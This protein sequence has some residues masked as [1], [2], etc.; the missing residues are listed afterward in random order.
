MSTSTVYLADVLDAQVVRDQLGLAE[1]YLAWLRDLEQI[2]PVCAAPLPDAATAQALLTRLA[3]PTEDVPIVLDARPD[4]DASR[5]IV[6]REHA[7]L[8]N[9]MGDRTIS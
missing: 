4:S 8:L 5:W 2:T 1:T 7:V 9:T 6:D 3:V